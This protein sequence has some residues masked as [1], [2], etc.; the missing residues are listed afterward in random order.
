M[1]V[2]TNREIIQDDYSN[3]NGFL[4]KLKG[5]GGKAKGFGDKVA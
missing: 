1:K 2:I 4:E 3:G 5:F